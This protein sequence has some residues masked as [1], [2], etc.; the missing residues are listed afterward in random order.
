MYSRLDSLSA[1]LYWVWVSS[2][3]WFPS[4]SEQTAA[5]LSAFHLPDQLLHPQG[6]HPVVHHLHAAHE[7]LMEWPSPSFQTVDHQEIFLQGELN[8]L[9]NHSL[10]EDTARTMESIILIS[11]YLATSSSRLL[12]GLSSQGVE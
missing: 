4:L 10:L 8:A 5:S 2:P 11:S 12:W 1:T 7:T 6:H 3:I 9:L